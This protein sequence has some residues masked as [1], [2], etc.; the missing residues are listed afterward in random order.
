MLIAQSSIDVEGLVREDFALQL[1]VTL[2]AAAIAGTGNA[3]Q[4][5]GI[6][7]TPG[8]GVEKFG[9]AADWAHIID[10]ETQI[11]NQNVSAPNC[12]YLT[13]PN[14]KAKLKAAPKIA[15]TFPNFIWEAAEKSTGLDGRYGMVNGYLAAATKNVPNDRMIFA[16]WSDLVIADWVGMDVTVDPYTLADKFQIK[17]TINMLVDIGLRHLGAFCV[18][19]DSAAQ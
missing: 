2:D 10:F 12:A 18:S 6:M 7:N 9:G 11:A 15:S 1:G 3:G 17:V 5:L 16:K 14:A 4:P 8:V 19:S 13:S